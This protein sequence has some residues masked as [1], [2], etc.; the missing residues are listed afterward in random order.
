MEYWSGKDIVGAAHFAT[1]L[2]FMDSTPITHHPHLFISLTLI[3]GSPFAEVGSRRK[4][5]A[6]RT[7]SAPRGELI[8]SGLLPAGGILQ[9][10]IYAQDFFFPFIKG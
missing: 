5:P 9:V 3:H 2:M 10:L 7:I 6:G 4:G 1:F 8:S